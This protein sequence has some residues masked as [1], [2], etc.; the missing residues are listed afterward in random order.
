MDNQN[1]Y[2][3]FTTLPNDA[4]GICPTSN[5]TDPAILFRGQQ[6]ANAFTQDS[7][8]IYWTVP[9]STG[10]GFSVWKGAK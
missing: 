10:A 8:A 1:F 9:S 2:G 5:C 4:V 3:T 7:T 6:Y